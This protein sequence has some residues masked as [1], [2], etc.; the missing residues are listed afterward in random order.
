MGDKEFKCFPV[1]EPLLFQAHGT[2]RC[3]ERDVNETDR[4]FGCAAGGTGDASGAEGE[5]GAAALPGTFGHRARDRFTDGAVFREEITGDTEVAL[6]GLVTIGDPATKEC[7]AAAADVRE[8]VGDLSAG[9]GF[10][11]RD[12]LAGGGEEF[13]D[14][15][16]EP[17]ITH[18]KN[19]F[20]ELRADPSFEI[21]RAHV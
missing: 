17:V 2:G 8:P 21:G 4:L 11:R 12:C 6:L 7:R 10:S 1:E 16:F 19:G 13:D 5:R 3:G 15:I 14:D 18:P 20:S 9:T